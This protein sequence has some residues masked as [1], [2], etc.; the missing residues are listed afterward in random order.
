MAPP[1]A[2]RRR[3][4]RPI[5]C[6]ANTSVDLGGSYRLT[7]NIDVTAGVRYSQDRDRI[8]PPAEAKADNQAVYVGTQFRF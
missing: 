8:V 3:A 7:R 4:S 1:A 6:W 5:W 2:A